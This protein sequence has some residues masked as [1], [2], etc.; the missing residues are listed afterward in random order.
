MLYFIYSIRIVYLFQFS[1]VMPPSFLLFDD[2]SDEALLTFFM[3]LF[4]FVLVKKRINCS[5][6]M[7]QLLICQLQANYLSNFDPA[8][9]LIPHDRVLSRSWYHDT[10]LGQNWPSDEFR[11]HFRVTKATFRYILEEIEDDITSLVP[12]VFGRPTISAHMKLC[13]FL[14]RLSSQ[15]DVIKL[16]TQFGCSE[17]TVIRST[18]EVASA[19]ID[20]FGDVIC[21]PTTIES[22]QAKAQKF[23]DVRPTQRTLPGIIGGIDGTF[24]NSSF[25]ELTQGEKNSY[26]NRKKDFSFNLQAVCDA[27]E[28]FLDVF[29]GFPSRAP[30]SA[31]FA[32]S[33]LHFAADGIFSRPGIDRQFY[34]IGDAGYPLRSWCLTPFRHAAIQGRPDRSRYNVSLSSSRVVIEQA[35]GHLKGRWR[36]LKFIDMEL[37]IAIIMVQCACILHN[38]CILR[39]DPYVPDIDDEDENMDDIDDDD[40]DGVVNNVR[41]LNEWRDQIVSELF[42]QP[43]S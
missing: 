6:F 4:I 7:R 43:N 32:A 38:I 35:F 9:R 5:R 26:F 34:I 28:L 23:R 29:I 30:D 15:S 31:V 13:I 36:R 3:Y 12:H 27:D 25:N 22:M 41:P 2:G 19:L 42:N 18:Y 33:P 37:P 16:R 20:H 11:R 21:F 17:S 1:T 40:E 39:E 8:G 14:Y 24:I 10:V